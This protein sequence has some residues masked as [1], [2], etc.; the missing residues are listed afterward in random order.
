MFV[1]IWCFS[2]GSSLSVSYMFIPSIKEL[3]Y[4]SLFQF[5][6]NSC[7]YL[8]FGVLCGIFCFVSF[9]VLWIELGGTQAGFNL[10]ILLSQPW[11][12]AITGVCLACFLFYRS[13]LVICGFILTNSH[14]H[15][16]WFQFMSLLFSSPSLLSL[17]IFLSLIFLLVLFTSTWRWN[18]LWHIYI[19]T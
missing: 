7:L 8:K 2:F 6:F 17:L 14:I 11:V 16:I 3:F 1:F 12:A 15:R 18:S 4:W 10:E 5:Y 9:L 13:I 19:C